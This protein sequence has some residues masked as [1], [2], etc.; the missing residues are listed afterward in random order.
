M[1]QRRH[2]MS[3]ANV[4]RGGVCPRVVGLT[5]EGDALAL[6]SALAAGMSVGAGLR[7]PAPV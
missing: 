4:P 3:Y 1:P 5:S 2:G 6:V 7:A